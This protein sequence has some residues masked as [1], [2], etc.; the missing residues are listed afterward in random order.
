MI[1]QIRIEKI[2]FAKFLYIHKIL[3]FDYL[4][5]FCETNKQ[6][7]KYII[8]NCFLMSK[9]KLNLMNNKWWDEKLSSFDDYFQNYENV[10]KIIY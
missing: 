4:N 3:K 7:S 8:M 6:M 2:E 9:K 1:T 5:C 10:D